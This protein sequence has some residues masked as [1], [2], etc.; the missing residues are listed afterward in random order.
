ML[1]RTILAALV[2][3]FSTG[4]SLF[5]DEVPKSVPI[6]RVHAPAGLL[7][8]GAASV[9]ITPRESTWMGGYSPM[10]DSEGIHD[11]L[12][13]RALV[14]ERGS[15]RLALV[16]VDCVGIQRQDRLRW[17]PLIAEAGFDPRLVLVAAS[18]TH[19]GPDT[20][21]LWGVPALVSGQ[22]DEVM[23]RLRD[24]VLR[25]LTLA[26]EQLRPAEI[27]S[28][29]TLL[30][31][32]LLRNRRRPG[33][34]DRRLTVLHVREVGAGPTIATLAELGSHAVV[35]DRSN[36]LFSADYP[37]WLCA[38]LEEHLG[39]VGL[40]VAGALGGHVGPALEDGGDRYVLAAAHGGLV[41]L[42]ATKVVERLS[43]YEAHPAVTALNSTIYLKNENVLYE[44]LSATG[45]FDREFFGDGYLA[46]EVNLWQLGSLC[47]GSIPGEITPDLGL[48]IKR[49][50]EAQIPLGLALLVG[51]GND[52][53]GYF[54]PAADYHLP[55]YSYERT[56]SPGYDGG[57]RVRRRLEDLAELLESEPGLVQTRR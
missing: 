48:R 33:L 2:L 6:H 57:D 46:T 30:E 44:L 37:A 27:A 43:N 22:S 13:A 5:R 17:D 28:G 21:G 42:E 35:V 3:C 25:A 20:L 10:R 53:L 55:F 12:Q 4:C 19:A 26:R 32:D 54:V 31:P 7:K 23:E 39:G 38:T 24:G 36:T 45:V 14:L 9:E 15:L 51:L 49:S 29:V 16:A 8:A 56:L 41:G 50:I 18:H 34:V 11:P 47:L 40:Y 1:P 52:E